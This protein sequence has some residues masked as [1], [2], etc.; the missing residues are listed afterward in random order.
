MS[1]AILLRLFKPSIWLA[2]VALCLRSRIKKL[3]Q[4]G[5]LEDKLDCSQVLQVLSSLGLEQALQ[6]LRCLEDGS[7]TIR[8][9]T[10]FVLAAANAKKRATPPAPGLSSL[11]Q[12]PKKSQQGVAQF[13]ISV[14]LRR[15]IWEINE[16][17][18]LNGQLRYDRIAP[19]LQVLSEKDALEVLEDLEQNAA[20][21]NDPTAYVL[22][23]A[24]RFSPS[25]PEPSSPDNE[26]DLKLRRRIGWLNNN[27]QFEVPLL[28]HKVRPDLLRIGNRAA[29]EVLKELENNVSRIGPDPTGWVISAAKEMRR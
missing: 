23:T 11:W 12:P 28:Y 13:A 24:R 7:S 10:S 6:I 18:G 16:N 21:V 9:P 2:Y 25:V 4:R 29:M 3:N 15:R 20:H 1:G 8:D 14:E 27:L 26:A 19:A 17:G 5:V 22:S